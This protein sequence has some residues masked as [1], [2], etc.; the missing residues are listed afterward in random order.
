MDNNLPARLE[1]RIIAIHEDMKEMITRAEF[2]AKIDPIQKLVY[3]MVGLIM[4][5]VVGSVM[6]DVVKAVSILIK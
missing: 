5:Y 4:V 2:R 6:T 3:G 1:E